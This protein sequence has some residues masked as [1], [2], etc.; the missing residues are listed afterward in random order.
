MSGLQIGS[1]GKG[2]N[3]LDDREMAR[4]LLVEY[5]TAEAGGLEVT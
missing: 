1:P 2:G 3:D 4:Q 5:L